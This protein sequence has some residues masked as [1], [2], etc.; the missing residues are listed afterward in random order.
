M[1]IKT[2][3]NKCHKFKSF[4]YQQVKLVPYQGAE[5]IDVTIIPRKN[6]LVLCSCCGQ[7]APG[8]DSLSERRFEFMPLW[9]YR[10]F[11]LYTLRRVSKVRGQG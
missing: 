2:I 5:V 10:V 11:F 9:G 7:P 6:A 1:L 8:Y 3:L 4:V